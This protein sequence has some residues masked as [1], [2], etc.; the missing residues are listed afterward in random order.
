MNFFKYWTF[1]PNLHKF[2]MADKKQMARL[3]RKFFKRAQEKRSESLSKPCA[4]TVYGEGAKPLS[5]SH[6]NTLKQPRV[7]KGSLFRVKIVFLAR[8]K[9]IKLK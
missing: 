8:E 7:K 4:I 5:K 6:D 9:H 1:G 2:K 3:L